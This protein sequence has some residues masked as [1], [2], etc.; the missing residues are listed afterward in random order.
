MD[1]TLLVIAQLAIHKLSLFSVCARFQTLRK[2]QKMNN[3]P[4]SITQETPCAQNTDSAPDLL[5]QTA[6]T[7][8][9]T[10]SP[11]AR[12]QHTNSTRHTKNTQN[13]QILSGS[14][15]SNSNSNIMIATPPLD[16]CVSSA[17]TP[18]VLTVEP[19]QLQKPN[20]QPVQYFHNAAQ[21]TQG[22]STNN[23][24]SNIVNGVTLLHT[25]VTSPLPI[26]PN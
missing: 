4:A 19:H 8:N 5:S 7:V 22:I 16:P 2:P 11:G 24:Q 10:H 18:A 12:N 1:F 25:S 14:S 23:Q 13:F 20:G 26:C 3:F 15:H 6:T 9:L 21:T 17:K